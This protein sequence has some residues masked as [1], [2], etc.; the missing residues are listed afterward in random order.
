MQ[1][2]HATLVQRHAHGAA[3]CVKPHEAGIRPRLDGNPYFRPAEDVINGDPGNPEHITT[4]SRRNKLLGNLAAGFPRG[5]RLVIDADLD[6]RLPG[7][8]SRLVF[9]QFEI[10][11]QAQPI[12]EISVSGHSPTSCTAASC[13]AAPCMAASSIPASPTG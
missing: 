2:Q 8:R 12:S 11:D 7:D 6:I 13:T 10:R 1:D 4:V 5:H 9:R 3:D